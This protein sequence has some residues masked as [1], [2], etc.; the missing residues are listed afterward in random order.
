MSMIAD[1]Q[2]RLRPPAA[3]GE[4]RRS[5]GPTE[6]C[7]LIAG[8][9]AFL[10]S[11]ALAALAILVEVLDGHV[12][13]WEFAPLALANLAIGFLLLRRIDLPRRPPGAAVLT[14]IVFGLL[15][16][17]LIS[18]VT[19]LLTGVTTRFDDAFYESVSG[20]STTG[21]SVLDPAELT[22]GV[23]FW[24]AGTQWLGGFLGLIIGVV[25][26]PFW[27]AGREFADPG[28]RS[29]GFKA[30]APTALLGLR[31]VAELYAALSAASIVLFFGAGM[32]WFDALTYGMTTI[33]TGGFANHAASLAAFDSAAIE[34][35][36]AVIMFVAGSS[37]V[38]IWWC[39]R[40]AVG[41]F[42]QATEMRVYLIVAAISTI[43]FAFA[44]TRA[45]DEPL[46]ALTALRHGAVTATSALSTTGHRVVDWGD[47][48]AGPTAA[49]FFIVLTGSMAGSIGGGYRWLRLI[50]AVKF[51]R[52]EVTMQLHPNAVVAVKIGGEPASDS[53]LGQMNAQQILV[54]VT[55]LVGAFG[56]AALG[57]SVLG[58]L[59]LTISAIST[60]GPGL[61]DV[62]T[63]EGSMIVSGQALSAPARM[64]HAV[65]M[66][67]GRISIYPVFTALGSLILG[68]RRLWRR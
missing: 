61:G 54:I 63:S 17:A 64:V 39:I 66:F 26:L 2:Q 22:H 25:L 56:L 42:W 44:E 13:D 4:S 19:Y 50:E 43:G 9:A 12:G 14:A 60:F 24:R 38:I 23:L 67:A 11:G 40:G 57:L 45:T 49:L 48:A 53:S 34:W 8:T 55:T 16:F 62:T 29:V 68:V 31:H 37:I 65:L 30:L 51:A 59:S 32:G 27:V 46:S 15:S 3:F 33:S 58:S 1:M 28:G 20:Y 7:L 36:A 18:T 47:W 41:S 52:R 6:S 21:L 35:V 10:G 5:A